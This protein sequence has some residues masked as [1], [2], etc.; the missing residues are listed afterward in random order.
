MRLDVSIAFVGTHVCSIDATLATK[1]VDVERVVLNELNCSCAWG[2][3]II[4]LKNEFLKPDQPLGQWAFG[5]RQHLFAV[6]K[7]VKASP[8]EAMTAYFLNANPLSIRR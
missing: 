2:I 3:G 5:A 7:V 6:P 1:G 4:N 8:A